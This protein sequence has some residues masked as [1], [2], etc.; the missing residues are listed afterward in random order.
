MASTYTQSIDEDKETLKSFIALDRYVCYSID[1][2]AL[3]PVDAIYLI[4]VRQDKKFRSDIKR[5]LAL[6]RLAAQ[7]GSGHAHHMWAGCEGGKASQLNGDLVRGCATWGVGLP[8]DVPLIVLV[9]LFRGPIQVDLIAK[10]GAIISTTVNHLRDAV[11]DLKHCA[12][13]HFCES[14]KWSLTRS[15]VTERGDLV[16]D[17]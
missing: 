16:S 10:P 8:I 14:F 6:Q 17:G 4:L 11:S 12:T 7:D 13:W 2:P 5:C 9:S 3:N 1:G 15:I